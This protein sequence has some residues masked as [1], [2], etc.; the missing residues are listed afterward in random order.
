MSIPANNILPIV[1]NL[2]GETFSYVCP[3]VNG[4]L[5]SKRLNI[6]PTDGDAF[7]KADDKMIV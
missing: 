5:S 2:S 3:K 7:V 1:R 4:K 6:A